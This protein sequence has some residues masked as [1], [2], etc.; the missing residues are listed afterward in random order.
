MVVSSNGLSTES[1]KLYY[2]SCSPVSSGILLGSLLFTKFV[3]EIPSIVSSPAFMFVGDT[4][5]F[6]AIRKEEDYVALQN[7]LNQLYSGLSSNLTFPNVSISIYVG[8]AHHYG[9]YYLNG[10][11]IVTVT[12]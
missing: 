9:L 2:K 5:I 6:C 8:P 10:I 1:N 7:D 12:Q 4:K 11:S 3:N